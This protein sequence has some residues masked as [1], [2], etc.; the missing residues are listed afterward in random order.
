MAYNNYGYCEKCISGFVQI[1]RACLP[2]S[3]NCDIYLPG[4][5]SKC[6]SC[7]QG[8]RVS[9]QQCF[10]VIEGCLN[11]IGLNACANCDKNYLLANGNCIFTDPNC[12]SMDS[13]GLCQQCK[14]GFLPSKSRCVYFDPYCLSYDV[15]TM[16]CNSS[17]S[18]F[19]TSGLSLQQQVGYLNFIMQASSASQG[20]SSA[21]FS[22]GAGQGSYTK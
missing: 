14:N 7:I 9:G 10:P 12:I 21:G 13:N 3:A 15:T 16:V 5:Q 1:S 4:D 19:S 17:A 2:I 11:Y 22:G 8:Y 20:Q 6:S 18:I